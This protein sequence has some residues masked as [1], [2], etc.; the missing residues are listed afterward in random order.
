[1]MVL[2]ASALFL[3][4]TARGQEPDTSNELAIRLAR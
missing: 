1:M 4:P 2:L 3:L